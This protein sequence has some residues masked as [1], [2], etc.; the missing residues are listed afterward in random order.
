MSA[1]VAF[2]ENA[3][4]TRRQQHAGQVGQTAVAARRGVCVETRDAAGGSSHWFADGTDLLGRPPGAGTD[5]LREVLGLELPALPGLAPGSVRELADGLDLTLEWALYHQEVAVGDPHV[6]VRDTRS[7]C[8]VE[9][10]L[11]GAVG[12]VRWDAADRRGSTERLYAAVEQAR[13]QA[14]LGRGDLPAKVPLGALAVVLDAGH[15][16]PFFHELVGHPME[17]DIVL[18]ESSWA[19][20]A[21]GE[22]VAP[23]WL[24]VTDDATVDG[25]GMRAAVDDEGTAVRTVHLVRDGRLAEVLAD[26]TTAALLGVP[27]N[28][29]GRRLDYR[30]PAIPRMR[31]TRA[32]ASAPGQPPDALRVHPRG[33]QLRWMNLL[34]GEFE[35]AAPGGLL[36]SGDGPVRRIG[37]LS[38]TGRA[39]EVLAALRPG[40]TPVASHTGRARGGCGKLGQFP[41]PTTF[42]NAGLW[43]PGEVLRVRA[44]IPR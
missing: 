35:F 10:R 11:P 4:V 15:A 27:G 25:E 6:P 3:A 29:H 14:A 21:L 36:D 22:P 39:P 34:T 42:A 12:L 24:Q 17:A 2:A 43:I 23:S 30:H 41:L 1:T 38:L 33:L 9:I 18:T 32:L 44:D 13:G 5:V 19:A 37:P 31:H 16:G 20:R 40:G 7:L 28:G 26:T 8:T